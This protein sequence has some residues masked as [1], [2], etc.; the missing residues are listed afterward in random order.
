MTSPD[1]WWGRLSPIAQ[2]RLSEEPSRPVPNDLLDDVSA[3]GRM[4]LPNAAWESDDLGGPY[5]LP[6]DVQRWI[7]ENYGPLHDDVLTFEGKEY[8]L[9][10]TRRNGDRLIGYANTEAAAEL[11]AA[12]IPPVH[13]LSRT[14][15]RSNRVAAVRIGDLITIERRDKHWFASDN[16]GELGA[17]KW[18]HSDEGKSHAVTGKPMHFPD[19]ATLRVKRLVINK[20]GFV[21]DFAGMVVS[22]ATR[23]PT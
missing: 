8:P 22:S 2:Q 11:Y 12:G 6:D 21:V 23:Q 19:A 5:F 4:A 15:V 13:G 20:E 16:H 17:L 14:G 9:I 10:S 3:A 7:Q 18:R 1:V